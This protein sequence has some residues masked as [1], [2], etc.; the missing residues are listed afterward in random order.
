MSRGTGSRGV[1]PA[2]SLENGDSPS[3]F[4]ASLIFLLERREGRA[5]PTWALDSRASAVLCGAVG[6]STSL[7]SYQRPAPPRLYIPPFHATQLHRRCV[8]D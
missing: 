4:S 3:P 2:H 1:C 6:R 5:E 7:N 8:F